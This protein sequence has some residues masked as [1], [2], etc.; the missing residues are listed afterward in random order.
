MSKARSYLWRIDTSKHLKIKLHFLFTKLLGTYFFV[1]L[2]I[3]VIG[4]SY[5]MLRK[6]FRV[7]VNWIVLLFLELRAQKGTITT[8]QSSSF[9]LILFSCFTI[10]TVSLVLVTFIHTNQPNLF[11]ACHDWWLPLFLITFNIRGT[12]DYSLWINNN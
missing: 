6:G 9:A 11:M 5:R 3:A 8:T 12:W 10:M 2:S 1:L 7:N 4:Y